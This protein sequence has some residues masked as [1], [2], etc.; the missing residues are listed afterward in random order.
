[1]K[2][3]D[4]NTGPDADERPLVEAAQGRWVVYVDH[5]EKMNEALER[6]AVLCDNAEEVL[7][8]ASYAP[9]KIRALK[10]KV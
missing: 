8:M 4:Y 3:L 9:D 5:V 6:A 10:E 7:G 1:M 2:R